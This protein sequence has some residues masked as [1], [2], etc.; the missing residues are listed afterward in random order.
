MH[1]PAERLMV[2]IPDRITDILVKGEYQPNYYNPGDLFGEV[3]LV[4]TTDDRP[5]LVALQ[6]T[7]GRAKLYVHNVPENPLLVSADWRRWWKKP[8]RDWAKPGIELARRI[9]PQLIRCHGADWNGYLASRI[10]RALGVPYGISLHI[11]PDINSVRR[12]LREP[13]TPEQDAH[14]AFFEYIESEGLRHADVVMPVYQSILPYLKRHGI[15][16]VEVCYNILNGPRLGQKTDYTSGHPFRIISVGRLI[17][18][19][20]P[21][22]LIMAIARLPDAD[23]TIVGDGP[24]RQALEHLVSELGIGARVRFRPAIGN[25]ELCGW[26]PEFDLFAV[27]TE[28]WELNKSVLEALLTGLPLVIN[29]RQGPPVP[30]LE[31][32]DIVRFVDNTTEGY[33][34]AIH[35]LMVDHREREG[36]GRRAF[37]HAQAQ[38]SPAVTEGKVV[39]IYRRLL[40]VAA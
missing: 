19:K 39:D 22:H 20:N 14:N 37:A 33:R 16:R 5:D 31:R 36:L 11:N 8:L 27:H 38:W 24:E 23:L 13:R 4:T 1:A 6:R 35:N 25:D 21:V 2:L 9:R 28:Y 12:F 3:H 29:R 32:S 17:Q 34:D 30:E 10:R 26:L 40:R 7:V 15:E 18:D